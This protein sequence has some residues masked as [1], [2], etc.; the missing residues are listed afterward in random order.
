MSNR[1]DDTKREAKFNLKFF[2]NK[3][4]MNEIFH[5]ICLKIKMIVVK[6]KIVFCYYYNGV[7]G[8]SRSI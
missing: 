7:Y 8:I 5:L 1:H 2:K 6:N 3:M 4:E